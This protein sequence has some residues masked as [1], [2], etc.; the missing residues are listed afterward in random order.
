MID[1]DYTADSL[2]RTRYDVTPELAAALQRELADAWVRGYRL[3]AE[4]ECD[5]C[6]TC[7]PWEAKHRNPYLSHGNDCA[8]PYCYCAARGGA[9]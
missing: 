6:Y 2:I 8:C 1:D 4:T 7:G 5:N 9:A 3:C